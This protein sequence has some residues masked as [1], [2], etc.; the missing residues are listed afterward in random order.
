MDSVMVCSLS[1]R[2][3]LE[4]G[5]RTKELADGTVSLS[6]FPIPEVGSDDLNPE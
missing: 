1:D 4:V 2:F 6:I 5:K 3:C